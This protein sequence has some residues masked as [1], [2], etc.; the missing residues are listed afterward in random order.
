VILL[1]NGHWYPHKASKK[2]MIDMFLAKQKV[3]H[4]P[5]NGTDAMRG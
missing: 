2:V 3:N 1:K 4:D 5:R